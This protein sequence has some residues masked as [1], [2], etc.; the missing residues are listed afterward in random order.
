MEHKMGQ[1]IRLTLRVVSLCC[2]SAF[3]LFPAAGPFDGKTFKGRIAYS[4]DGN[5]NDPDDW[6]AS[7]VVLALFAEFGVKDKLVHFDYN[8]ILTD[9]HAE[10]EKTHEKSVLGAAEHYGYDRK[11]FHDCRQNADAAIVSITKAVNESSEANPLYFIVAGP[12][13]VP[14]MGLQKSRPEARKHVYVI[15]HSNWNDGLVTRYSFKNTKRDVIAL[16]INWVQ[17]RDQN[18]LLAFSRYGTPAQPGEFAPYFWMRDSKDPKVRFLWDRM[19]VSTRPDPSDSG[20]AYFLM[21]GD[22]EADPA[23]YKRVLEDN[24]VPK[25]IDIRQMVRIEAENFETLTG[26]ELD[27]TDTA[28]SHRTGIKLKG[29]SAGRA[30]TRFKQPYTTTRGR[31]DVEVRYFDDRGEP[32]QFRLFVNDKL[33]GAEWKSAGTGQGW[34]SHA[35]RGIEIREG[36]EIRIEAS[37]PSVRLDY[38]QLNL[39]PR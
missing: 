6:A 15:S 5:H 14:V 19:V 10:W 31:Y 16:G 37:G 12:M 8:S 36:D 7:P 39:Q 29:G 9:T 3:N 24:V 38:V 32:S 30:L 4:A 33:R 13:Q 34:T 17:I 23:K 26:Y 11:R 22:E 27:L 20:M 18:P 28:A 1:T 35:I 21:T 2:L 25:P